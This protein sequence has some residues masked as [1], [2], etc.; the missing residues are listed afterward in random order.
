[1]TCEARD[2]FVELVAASNNMQVGGAGLEV[3]ADE[4]D[5]RCKATNDQD[6]KLTVYWLRYCGMA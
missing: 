5:F 4:M 3:Q 1:M 2:E 6:G